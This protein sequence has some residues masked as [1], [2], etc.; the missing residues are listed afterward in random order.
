[1]TWVKGCLKWMTVK[2]KKDEMTGE[3]VVKNNLN[4]KRERE[5]KEKNHGENCI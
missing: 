4:L 1:M 2:I 3:Y 5:E